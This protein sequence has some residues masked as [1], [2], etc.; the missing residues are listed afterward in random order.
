MDKNAY[1]TKK[2]EQLGIVAGICDEIKL[3]DAIDETV[4]KPNRKVSVGTAVKAMILNALGFSNRA[5]YLTPTFYASKPVELL[6][7]K[8]IQADDLNDDSLGTALDALYENGITEVFYNVSSQA[9]NKYGISHRFIHLDS[10]TFSLH[11]KYNSEDPDDPTE[12]VTITKG[13]SKDSRPDLNQVVFQLICSYRS[14][15]PLWVEV[16]SG[17]TN[18]KSSF[19]KT[20]KA[21]RQQ[22]NQKEMPYVVA[23]SALYSK[24]SLQELQGVKW[25]TRVPETIREAKDLINSTEKKDMTEIS[26]SGYSYKVMKSNYSDIEQR[27][28]VVYSEKAFK[29]EYT[30]LTKR[31]RKECDKQDKEVW[32]LS[33]KAFS[34][35]ADA[36]KAADGFS[37]KM[38]YHQLEYMVKE[39]NRYEKKGRPTKDSLVLDKEYFI[40]GSLK[41]DTEK[42]GAESDRKGYFII[43]TNE[44]DEKRLSSEQLLSVYKDQGV[45]VERGFRFLKDPMFYAESL[46]LKSPSRIMAL[47]MV[48]GLS[49]LVYSLAERKVREELKKTNK[50]VPNQLGKPTSTP[51]LRWIFQMFDGILHMKIHDGTQIEQMAMNMRP[52]HKAIIQAFGKHVEKMYFY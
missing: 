1:E 35:E 44:M 38:K 46:Y 15:I 13:H 32:H 48:M 9:L 34:C 7:G 47:L 25:V 8:G 30:T 19:K 41:I 5:L 39:E 33:K 21:Y 36:V 16:L 14:T 40:S 37:R 24:T 4:Q 12:V 43:A 28:L 29:R 51:T 42:V 18:D 52:E 2:L 22:M 20:I 11:G 50:T 23:D 26:D 3:M 31:I 45:S 27:W 17:N 10:T 49:L 6:L